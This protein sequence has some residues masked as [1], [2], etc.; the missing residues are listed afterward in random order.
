MVDVRISHSILSPSSSHRWGGGGEAH[1]GRKFYLLPVGKGRANLGIHRSAEVPYYFFR[2]SRCCE[3]REGEFV[4][5]EKRKMLSLWRKPKS[6]NGFKQKRTKQKTER[7][8]VRVS[9]WG[10][11][12]RESLL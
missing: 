7:Q 6:G 12:G 10:W 1:K 5:K 3:R 2:V 8:C 11:D 9:G 4:L